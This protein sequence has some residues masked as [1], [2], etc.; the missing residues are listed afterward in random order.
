MRYHHDLTCV[1]FE[2][3]QH[4]HLHTVPQIAVKCRERLIQKYKRRFCNHDA[5]ESNP[6]LLA[7]GQFSRESVFKAI[8]AETLQHV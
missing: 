8:H 5:R 6:L 2:H 1:V 3:L 4:F 7:S